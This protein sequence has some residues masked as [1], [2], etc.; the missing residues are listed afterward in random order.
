VK[1]PRHEP[2]IDEFLNTQQF[3]EELAAYFPFSTNSVFDATDELKL[4]IISA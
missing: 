1:D 4:Y 2:V 3:W